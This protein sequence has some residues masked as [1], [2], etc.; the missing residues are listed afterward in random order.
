MRWLMATIVSR[1]M[2]SM[3][4]VSLL[5]TTI[6]TSLMMSLAWPRSRA[7]K[8]RLALDRMLRVYIKWNCHGLSN[9]GIKDVIYDSQAIR[10]FLGIDLDR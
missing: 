6:P 4:F 3:A 5:P 10:R 9:E 7:G 1:E 2:R 8:R